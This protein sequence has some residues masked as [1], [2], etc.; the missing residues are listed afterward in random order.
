V[1]EGALPAMVP[2]VLVVPLIVS[3]TVKEPKLKPAR[4]NAELS[5]VYQAVSSQLPV[6]VLVPL[7]AEGAEANVQEYAGEMLL[8]RGTT[9]AVPPVIVHGAPVRFRASLKFTNTS[10]QS[11]GLT[12]LM[13]PDTFQPV[14]VTTTV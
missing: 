4:P 12:T 1:V 10:S 5:G 7:V 13:L 11:L 8:L 3:V 6:A 2:N 14:S 9:C